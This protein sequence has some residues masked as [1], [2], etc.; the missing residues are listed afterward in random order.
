VTEWIAETNGKKTKGR[1]HERIVFRH[2]TITLE[3]ESALDKIGGH[4]KDV[5]LTLRSRTTSIMCDLCPW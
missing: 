5:E 3:V 1:K 4:L 2:P